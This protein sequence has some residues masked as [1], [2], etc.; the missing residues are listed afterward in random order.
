MTR[1]H[2]INIL[3]LTAL[4]SMLIC[5]VNLISCGIK[6]EPLL[7]EEIMDSTISQATSSSQNDASSQSIPVIHNKED[8]ITYPVSQQDSS[9]QIGISNGYSN[10]SDD[11][12]LSSS[13]SY[14]I[15]SSS[16][17]KYVSGLFIDERDGREYRTITNLNS[18]HEIFAQN[19]NFGTPKVGADN[20]S[21]STLKYCYNNDTLNC[22]K[23]GG[24]YTWSMALN[25]PF[26]CDANRVKAFKACEIITYTDEMSKFVKGICP[27]NWHILDSNEWNEISNNQE[28]N[29]SQL[30]SNDVGWISGGENDLGF[31]MEP[32][33]FRSL[34]VEYKELFVSALYWLPHEVNE[35]D[36]LG[37]LSEEGVEKYV[38]RN[39][40]KAQA[41]SVRCVKNY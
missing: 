2:M 37:F 24:L 16:A 11:K 10:S 8:S 20:P 41:F 15:Q 25:L 21:S 23:Y 27:D 18:N 12:I 31:S 7:Q 38:L 9:A 26:Y 36:G 3:R 22:N 19:L 4:A 1:L 39:L 17:I 34:Y 32:G 14:V 30:R 35:V 5:A 6:D 33:G 28:L 29:D 40:A 13:S